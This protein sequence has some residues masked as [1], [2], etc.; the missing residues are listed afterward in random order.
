MTAGMFR[1]AIFINVSTV[2]L[3]AFVAVS[4]GS[5]SVPATP[6]A[7][8]TTTSALSLTCTGI[9]ASCGDAMQGQTVTFIAD[10]GATVRS[11]SLDFGDGTTT[12]LGALSAR[13][14]VMHIYVQTGTYTARLTAIDAS[15]QSQIATQIVR[16][17]TLVTASMGLANLGGFNVLGTAD[18]SG[19]T[20]VLYEWFFEGTTANVATTANQARYTFTTPGFKDCSVTATLSDGRKVRASAA[21]VVE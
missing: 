6:G 17:G 7:P 10:P 15:G 18:V 14:S 8:S 20:V 21:I 16:V 9:T 5:D 12:D 19:A 3:A 11:A 2:L 4:C 13:A 1:Y